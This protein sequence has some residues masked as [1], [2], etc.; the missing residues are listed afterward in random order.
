PNLR[1]SSGWGERGE[2]QFSNGF[3]EFLERSL[4]TGLWRYG[5]GPEPPPNGAQRVRERHTGLAGPRYRA[6]PLRLVQRA[7]QGGHDRVQP[8]Q[9]R[10]G[11][12]HRLLAPPAGRLQAQV[13]ALL[14][15]RGLDAPARRVVGDD[16]GRRERRVGG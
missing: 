15:E 13:R 1:I 4:G 5:F 3:G 14:L 11:A 7:E 10:G 16:L 2:Q 8:Q 12:Q 9:A 6:D